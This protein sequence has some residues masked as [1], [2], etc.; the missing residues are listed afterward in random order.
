MKKKDCLPLPQPQQGQYLGQSG[1][2]LLLAITILVEF[3]KLE[4]ILRIQLI[5]R[6]K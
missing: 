4:R 5:P 3:S 6:F 1:V 2:T